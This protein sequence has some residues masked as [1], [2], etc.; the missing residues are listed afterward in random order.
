MAGARFQCGDVIC[1][2]KISTIMTDIDCK[3]MPYVWALNIILCILCY[4]GSRIRLDA[5][6]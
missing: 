3:N 5:G 6:L 2:G 4:K 1:D